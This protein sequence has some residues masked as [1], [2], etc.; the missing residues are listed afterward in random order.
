MIRSDLA[1]AVAVGA[2]VFPLG[3]PAYALPSSNPSWASLSSSK[4]LAKPSWKV[5]KTIVAHL[6]DVG[7]A[8]PHSYGVLLARS[9]RRYAV[10]WV[11]NTNSGNAF[12]RRGTSGRWSLLETLS[13]GTDRDSLC[14]VAK[15]KQASIPKSVRRDF[16]AA[17]VCYR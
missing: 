5:K 4:T 9:D 15:L 17:R 12:M 7:G 3:I 11:K 13:W 2:I 16:V 14:T 1:K 8:D 10:L 6:P